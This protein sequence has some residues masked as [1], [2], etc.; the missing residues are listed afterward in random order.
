MSER[1]PYCSFD[2]TSMNDYCDEHRPD[3]RRQ[4]DYARGFRDAVAQAQAVLIEATGRR[5]V[6]HYEGQL[7]VP[8]GIIAALNAI[9]ALE[10]KS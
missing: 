5:D 4:S 6:P 7:L 10:P 3:R 1:C 9:A 8:P 2:P